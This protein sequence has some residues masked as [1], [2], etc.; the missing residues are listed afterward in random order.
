V[1]SAAVG[2]PF[3]VNINQPRPDGSAAPF[4]DLGRVS[5]IRPT[6]RSS[7]HS[8]QFKLEKRFGQGLFLLATHTWSKSIDTV[9]SALFSAET[10]GGV[11]NIFDPEQNRAVSDWD[12]PHRFAASYVW[13]VPFGA[14]RRFGGD[15]PAAARAL[16]GNWQLSGIFVARSGVPGTVTVGSPGSDANRVPGGDARPNLLHDPNLPASDRSVDHW[17]DTTAFVAARSASGGLLP[18]NAGR[19][20]IRGP[21]YVNLDL[22]FVKFLPFGG[23]PRWQLR[24]E[25]F[26]ALNRPHFALPVLKMS[27]P[28]FGKI[29]HTRNSTNFGSTATSFASRMIQLAVKLEF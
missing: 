8:G 11:Q 23:G 6:A 9:S 15:A 7:Y 19:N 13:D 25:V 2:L 20:I 17:F 28:A 3:S 26:N 16:L 14:G 18:G 5:V 12:V 10:T 27:D 21:A 22:G 1:G 29:T 4:K 24:A